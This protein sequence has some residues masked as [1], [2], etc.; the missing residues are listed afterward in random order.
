MATE[1][2]RNENIKNKW[3][4]IKVGAAGALKIGQDTEALIH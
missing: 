1:I 4:N 3:K 2:E